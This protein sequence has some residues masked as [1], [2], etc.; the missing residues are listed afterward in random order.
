MERFFCR[1]VILLVVMGIFFAIGLKE[2]L[3]QQYLNFS[4]KV[5]GV[6]RG[7]LSVEGDKGQTMNFAV[8]RR[9][10]YIPSRLPVVGERV[11]VSYF[12]QRGRQVAYQVE[13]LS[14]SQP[15]KKK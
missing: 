2:A 11:K 5:V 1:M 7:N 12:L 8:G 3:T 14:S 6:H 9:T 10:I 15:P 4:G 13:I